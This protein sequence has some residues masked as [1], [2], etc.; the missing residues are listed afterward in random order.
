MKTRKI[1]VKSTKGLETQKL[2]ESN[3]FRVLSWTVI[4]GRIVIEYK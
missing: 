4:S 1:T 2:L 3:G